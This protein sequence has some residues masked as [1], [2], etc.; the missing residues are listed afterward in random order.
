[1]ISFNLLLFSANIPSKC[2]FCYFSLEKSRDFKSHTCFSVCFSKA[3]PQG[4][5]ENLACSVICFWVE[6]NTCLPAMYLYLPIF[7]D[8]NADIFAVS[9]LILCCRSYIFN[10]INC[11]DD[12]LYSF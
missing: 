10:L 5:Y 6:G 8:D 3:F 11:H 9:L 2:I 7:P 4:E 12:F 1:M